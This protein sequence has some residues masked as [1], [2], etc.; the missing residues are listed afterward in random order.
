MSEQNEKDNFKPV[1]FSELTS[2]NT[3]DK[4]EINEWID[5]MENEETEKSE[6]KSFISKIGN[7]VEKDKENLRKLRDFLLC[8][9]FSLLY[10][11]YSAIDIWYNDYEF[12]FYR[13]RSEA[14]GRDL[15]EWDQDDV[16][17]FFV[18]A[19]FIVKGVEYRD[20]R[21]KTNLNPF[22]KN[23]KLLKPGKDIFVV[24]LSSDSEFFEKDYNYD[25]YDAECFQE[26]YSDKDEVYSHREI[27][28]TILLFISVFFNAALIILFLITLKFKKTENI[29]SGDFNKT[30]KLEFIEKKLE[31]F[32]SDL[33]NITFFTDDGEKTFENATYKTQVNVSRYITKNYIV[34]SYKNI[35]VKDEPVKIDIF[36]CS[37]VRSISKKRAE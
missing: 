8:N 35:Y 4:N 28:K 10:D 20:Y 14:E 32:R 29:K 18:N 12:A 31:P 21:Y 9:K 19:G 7:S 13:T 17:E 11:K 5:F 33:Y 2:E 26:Q 3:E 27:K 34:Y 36:P 24:S 23:E 16:K 30:E 22:L 37:I 6:N 25:E 1:E 15:T